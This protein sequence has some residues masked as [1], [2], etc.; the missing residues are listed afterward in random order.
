M[1][2]VIQWGFFNTYYRLRINSNIRHI[3]NNGGTEEISFNILISR[4]NPNPLWY[5]IYSFHW[6]LHDIKSNTSIKVQIVIDMI[7]H[8]IKI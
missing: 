3:E 5:F 6:V 7:V 1:G 2:N 8:D 4:L